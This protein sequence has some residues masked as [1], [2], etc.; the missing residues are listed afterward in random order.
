MTISIMVALETNEINLL[1]L[2]GYIRSKNFPVISTI[3]K[4]NLTLK[5]LYKVL[6]NM[7]RSGKLGQF[8]ISLLEDLFHNWT[9][10]VEE[11]HVFLRKTTVVQHTD[12]LLKREAS[13]RISLNNR[14]VTH[15]KSAHKLE[16]RDLNWEVERS[17]DSNGTVRNTVSSS[18]LTLVVTGVSQ[19]AGKEANSV[20]AEVFKE[21]NCHTDFSFSLL[22]RFGCRSHDTFDEEIKDFRIVHALNSFAAN[23]RQH[24]VSLL[25]FEWVMKTRLG[26][27]F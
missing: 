5:L 27:L 24:K 11:V 12:P 1:L 22:A 8:D 17:D 18:E 16:H 6:T 7:G 21:I 26:A 15:E 25:V 20:T 19:T 13:S 2:L 14:L 4:S 10:S 9:I 23:L 3:F